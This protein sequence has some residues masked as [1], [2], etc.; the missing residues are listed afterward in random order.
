ML[1]ALPV[2]QVADE[3][4][5]M[6]ARCFPAAPATVPLLKSPPANPHKSHLRSRR[7]FERASYTGHDFFF[8][9]PIPLYPQEAYGIMASILREL[10][11]PPSTDCLLL[12]RQAL[13]PAPPLPLP[14]TSA[15]Q[16]PPP[17]LP[18]P[19]PPP[20]TAALAALLSPLCCASL[21]GAE[22]ITQK[23]RATKRVPDGWC[24]TRW[25]GHPSSTRAPVWVPTRTPPRAFILLAFSVRIQH[26]PLPHRVPCIEGSEMARA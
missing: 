18:P 15:P 8:S 6:A 4:P 7:L 10:I 26:A 13:P 3:L 16:A 11:V 9:P 24:H 21:Q 25:L 22:S 20:A 17:T 19:P 1:R 23:Y 14:G 5:A 2:A 12:A